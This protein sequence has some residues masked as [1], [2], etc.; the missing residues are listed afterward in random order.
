MYGYRG[1]FPPEQFNMARYCL[2]T[3]A[4]RPADK[5]GLV[6]VRGVEDPGD[7]EDWT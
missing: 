6:V 3:G 2:E 7:T 4:L 1:D 5:T